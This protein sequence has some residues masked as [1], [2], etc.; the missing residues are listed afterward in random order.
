MG[1][2][3]ICSTHLS[4]KRYNYLSQHIIHVLYHPRAPCLC[5]AALTPCKAHILTLAMTVYLRKENCP[6]GDGEWERERLCVS[7]MRG[8]EGR[9]KKV[10]REDNERGREW[11]IDEVAR[12]N[13]KGRK[14]KLSSGKKKDKEEKR[15]R[16]WHTNL[17]IKTII[18]RLFLSEQKAKWIPLTKNI[19]ENILRI[20]SVKNGEMLKWDKS[21]TFFPQNGL[22]NVVFSCFIK[23]LKKKLINSSL[24]I[25][26]PV[27]D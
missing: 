10:E 18:L 2:R 5:L 4:A 26:S 13:E 27:R 7:K 12:E 1:R 23:I 24:F 22:F 3:H 25:F 17:L 9:A 14:R 8:K 6:Q 21:N 15:E 16:G 19:H 20:Y 11:E